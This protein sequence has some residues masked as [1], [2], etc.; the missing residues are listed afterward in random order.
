M[1]CKI[2]GKLIIHP[3]Y[4]IINT[5]KQE[6]TNGKL[7]DVIDKK[8][9]VV[10]T[11][12][13]HSGGHERKPA[14]SVFAKRDDPDT[15]YGFVH[16]FACGYTAP[17]Y[18]FVA[19]CFNEDE[20]FG[21]EWLCAR[22]GNIFIEEEE[23]L[24]EIELDNKSSVKVLPQSL[25][26]DYNHFH[27][28]LINRG[29]TPEVLSYFKVGY[30]TNRQMV[31]F[32][33]WDAHDNLVMITARSVNSKYFYIEKDVDKPIYLYNYVKKLG[34]DT[35][36]VCES[37]INCLTLW[38][39]GI[40]AVGLIGTGSKNQYE[41]L[42]RSGIRHYYLAFDG[43]DAG[44]KGVSRFIQNMPNDVMIDIILL[45]ENKDVND[46][47]YEQFQSLPVISR[48]DWVSK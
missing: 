5:I 12:P 28:Y 40:P 24:P 29:I 22:F 47:T 18:R 11:C 31:T 34:Y 17:L 43:D 46:L 33:V 20:E 7:K 39:R 38:S 8:D 15:E 30:D 35:V 19:D 10:V 37:Q 4:A 23:I 27:P 3:I 16:C 21:K 1:D 14:C 6:L 42:K 45:P 41:I 48:W 36:T 25:L 26:D 44:R 32:P 2:N 9:N 13:I